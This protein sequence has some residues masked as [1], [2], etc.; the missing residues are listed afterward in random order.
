MAEIYLEGA[1][2]SPD[3]SLSAG[4]CHFYRTG[5]AQ[6]KKNDFNKIFK[7]NWDDFEKHIKEIFIKIR[8]LYG[9][10]LRPEAAMLF[11]NYEINPK[12]FGGELSI[13]SNYLTI[14]LPYLD[15]D[16][17]KFAF[18]SEFSN[19]GLSP[20][21]HEKKYLSFKNYIFQSKIICSNP[22]FRK[23]YINGMPITLYAKGDNLL[24]KL[25]RLF[26]R[27]FA[28]LKGEHIA[29][30]RLEDWENWSKS[31]LINEFDELLNDD[32]LILDYVD[33]EIISSAK[34]SN[35]IHLINKLVTTEILLG[36][37]KNRWDI[38]T[39]N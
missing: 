11:D 3:S 32:S 5:K 35:D 14:R 39:E 12:Y 2:G 8:E 37:I 31:V 36:L 29:H 17:L 20:Y 16:I 33:K 22:P 9:D 18:N 6:V 38:K 25:S 21:I 10:P 28:Y 7:N 24:F 1:P 26:I 34:E 13:A 19:L 15:M 23:T 30:N 4:M 27:G